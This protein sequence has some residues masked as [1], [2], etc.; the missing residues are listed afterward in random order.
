MSYPMKRSFHGGDE[1][2]AIP[3]ATITSTDVNHSSS[4]D[5]KKIKSSNATH[6]CLASSS[7]SDELP[8]ME[9]NDTKLPPSLVANDLIY[10][11]SSVPTKVED[12]MTV[13]HLLE[14]IST[15]A[16]SVLPTKGMEENE[17]DRTSQ[18]YY[19]DSYAHHAIH[20]EMLKDEVRTRTYEMAICQ[21]KHLFHDKV[22]G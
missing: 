17:V 20:E 13:C 1:T 6:H 16:S 7:S 5:L 19:F 14:P 9:G 11:H 21:N 15:A 3:T 4:G 8:T 12:E 22:R 2:S 10:H 18:D